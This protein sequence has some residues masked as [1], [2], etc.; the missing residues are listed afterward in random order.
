MALAMSCVPCSCSWVQTEC[1][2]GGRFERQLPAGEAGGA[3]SAS[4]QLP[5]VMFP[6]VRAPLATEP[7]AAP[8]P[9]GRDVVTLWATLD[10]MPRVPFAPLLRSC[11]HC[12]FIDLPDGRVFQAANIHA[13]LTVRRPVK[14]RVR[15]TLSSARLV[16]TIL[17][18]RLRP[19]CQ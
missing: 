8:P 10:G 15:R 16:V 2:V 5:C 6:A 13:V 11:T 18:T 4:E 3:G 9:T 12:Y 17:P 1:A 7:A 19:S 14:V